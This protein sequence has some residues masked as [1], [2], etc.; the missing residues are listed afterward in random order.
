MKNIVFSIIMVALVICAGVTMFSLISTPLGEK[1]IIVSGHSDWNP[2][3]RQDGE[4]I[5]GIGPDVTKAVFKDLRVNVES[6]YVGPWDI[7]Q[8]KAKTGEITAI[9]ALYKTREREE[10]LQYSI[11]YTFDPIVLFFKTGKSFAYN[12]KQDLIGKK[13]VAT[14][15]DSYGQEIDD[16]IIQGQLDIKRVSTPK[17]A[18]AMVQQGKVDYFIY[19]V[20]A[21][22]RVMDELNLFGF[23]ESK[24]VSSQPF[25]IGISKKSPYASVEYMDKINASLEKLIAAGEIPIS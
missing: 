24:V 23:E 1:T 4:N 5:V 13:G 12:Q 22:R 14:I 10:Y 17:E 20:Y 2:I 9:V 21:G 25:Y 6:K 7:V 3:M 11:P 18:F 16:F 15:G 8:E 19:S